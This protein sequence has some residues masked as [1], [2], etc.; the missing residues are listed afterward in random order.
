MSIE[1]TEVL[2]RLV[3]LRNGEFSAEH[4]RYLLLLDFSAEQRSQYVSLAMKAQ[5]GKLTPH[6]TR[7]LDD[8]LAA[9]ALLIILQSKVRSALSQHAA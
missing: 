9:N 3:A 4:A 8:L 5:D 6:E 7:E 1:L 2:D